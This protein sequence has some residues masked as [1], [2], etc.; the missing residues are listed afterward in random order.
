MFVESRKMALMNLFAGSSGDAD[1]GNGLRTQ[2]GQKRV[3]QTEGAGLTHI[4]SRA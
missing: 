2:R 3:G 1:V 4:H